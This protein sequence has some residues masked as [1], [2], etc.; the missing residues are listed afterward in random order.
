MVDISN[1]DEVFREAT[2][3]GR[4]KLKPE[5]IK[6]ISDGKVEKG[7]PLA[8][9]E[10]AAILSAKNTPQIIP[11]C[12]PIPIS[13][14]QTE[15]KIHD[16][17]IEVEISV[18]SSAKT[19]VE[20]EALVATAT[21]LLTIWDMVKKVEKDEDGQFPETSIENIKVKEKKKAKT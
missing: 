5:T 18:R 10:I 17:Y 14:V 16:N 11:F 1:K 4:I 13:N 3:I 21:Y 19:G 20:M 2:V 9:A 8:V 12:H 7:D 15:A 6:L